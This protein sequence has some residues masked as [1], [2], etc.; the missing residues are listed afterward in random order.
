VTDTSA[1][2]SIGIPLLPDLQPK[3]G[4]GA[5]GPSADGHP[6]PV[7]W[8]TRALRR[9]V[10][11]AGL[12][13]FLAAITGRLDLLVL[14]LPFVVGTAWSLR[15]R[16]T[17]EP[18]VTLGVSE[19]LVPEGEQVRVIVTV[20]NPT[21]TAFDFVV[22]GLRR[23]P[24]LR[25][26][27]GIRPYAIPLPAGSEGDI[28]LDGRT[29]RWGRHALGPARAYAVACDGLLE[30]HRV[31]TPPLWLRVHPVNEDFQAGEGMPRAAGLAGTHHSRRPGEGGELAGV[32]PFAPGDR[33][34]RIDWR[35]SL[36][37]RELH[38]SAT[39]SDRD[40]EVVILLDVL[41]E[42]GASGGVGGAA[43]A[44]DTAVRAAAGIAEHYLHR[45]DRVSL[46]EFG[47]KF[48]QL[49][50]ASGRRQYHAVLEWLLDITVSAGQVDATTWL[51]RP[52]LLPSNALVVALTPLVDDRSAELLAGLA[53][54]GRFLVA[55]DTLP[56][57][58]RPAAVN[59]W[60]DVAFR[61]WRLE[62]ENMLG[63]LREHG[64]PVVAWTGS[65]SLDQVLRDVARMAGSARAVVR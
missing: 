42:V 47:P 12:L 52:Y 65:G 15:R 25:M 61:L 14:A 49:R 56:A 34:R 9:A 13:M 54:A 27:R 23:S 3:A 64:V 16:P 39:L 50:P 51:Q 57:N 8:P 36:R 26:Q 40:A 29:L 37:T 5:A 63:Q 35:V 4:R 21:D 19:S 2:F 32:R 38:V 31:T 43:S 41:H 60:S 20:G 18:E 58:A 46:I 48:R 1:K 53:R 7:W 11:L 33:L 6:P 30:S 28:E 45:G 62:R 44:L 10:G 17:V 55:V 22:T 24:W 59:E